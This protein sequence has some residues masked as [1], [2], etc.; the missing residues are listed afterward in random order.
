M[1]GGL[2]YLGKIFYVSEEYE[3]IVDAIL[4][5]G[6][7]LSQGQRLYFESADF[8]A[9]GNAILKRHENLSP[10]GIP[11]RLRIDN[12]L[13]RHRCMNRE[14][15]QAYKDYML[16]AGFTYP[17]AIG[18]LDRKIRKEGAVSTLSWLEMIAA[19]MEACDI[20]EDDYLHPSHKGEAIPATYGFH[21]V[22]DMY[23]VDTELPWMLRQPNL[24]QRLITTPE[25]CIYSSKKRDLPRLKANLVKLQKGQ[26]KVRDPPAEEEWEVIWYHYG[27]R[28][29]AF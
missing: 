17:A 6:S 2:T 27:K 3:D 24:V 23:A 4:T 10:D 14:Q 1:Q 28:E 9:Q 8:E 29:S 22:D 16:R 20:G 7:E 26:I 11:E 15:A 12:I 5:K 18:E 19:E 21:K 13:L 25:R